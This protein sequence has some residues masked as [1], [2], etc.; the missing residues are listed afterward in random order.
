MATHFGSFR[1]EADGDGVERIG[2]SY[3]DTMGFVVIGPNHFLG[4]G[5]PDVAGLQAGQPGR[6]GLIESTDAGETSRSLSRG[7]A[8]FHGLAIADGQLYGWDSRSSQF[9]ASSDRIHWETRS[10]LEVLAF[11]IDPNDAEHLV[12]ATSDGLIDSDDGGRS[13][14]DLSGPTLAAPSWDPVPGLFG[15]DGGGGV[16]RRT[17]SG[18]DQVGP[19][20][21]VPQALLVSA[22]EVWAASDDG[23]GRTAILRSDDGG[24]TWSVRYRDLPP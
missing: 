18:W 2:G 5:H 17:S 19:L 6:R 16:W 1:V 21:G 9:L 20:P 15:A 12:G 23:S 24:A 11:V 3:Q 13:W 8:D 7:E 22:E 4:S 10:T 14:V